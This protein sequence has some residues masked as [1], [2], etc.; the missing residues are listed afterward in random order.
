M[1]IRNKLVLIQLI[2]AFAVLVSASGILFVHQAN[3]SRAELVNSLSSTAML[4]GGNS[5]STLV[6]LDDV[7]AQRVL[8]SLQVK[9]AIVN[10]C[11]YDGSGTL[12]AAYSREG[13]DE[14][15]FPAGPDSVSHAFVD[16]HLLLFQPV[17][18]DADIIGWVF[19]RSDLSQLDELT[20]Q[21]VT[22][23]IESVLIGMILS[24]LLALLLQ[25]TISQPILDLVTTTRDVSQTGD[26]SR[27][28][29]AVADDEL[30][31]LSATFNEMLQQ[32]EGRDASLQ[33]ARDTLELRVDERTRELLQAKEQLEQALRSE[34][35]ARQAAEAANRTKTTFLANMSHEIRTPMNAILGYTQI[36]QGDSNLNTEHLRAIDAIAD[37]GEHLRRLINDVL[38]ISKIEAGREEFRPSEFDLRRVVESVSIMFESHCREKGLAWSLEENITADRVYGDESKLRQVLINLLGNAVKF[39]SQG[40]VTLKVVSTDDVHYRFTVSDTG[41]GIPREHWSEIFEP[42]Q[43]DEQGLIQGGTG[44]G[45]AIARRQVEI[46]GG[47]LHLEH[48]TSAGSRFSFTALL[49]GIG[50]AADNSNFIT[51]DPETDEISWSRVQELEDG[52]KVQALIVDD[53]PTNRDI[54]EQMLTRI[55][56]DV[57]AVESGERAIQ[58]VRT[59]MPDIVFMD[60]RM[61]GG[62]TGV[63]AMQQLVEEHGARATKIVAVTASVFEHQRQSFMTAGFEGFIGKPLR[64]E[65][66]YACLS[67]LLGVRYRLAPQSTGEETPKPSVAGGIRLP[68]V[69]HAGLSAAAAAH[70]I[71]DLNRELDSLEQTGVEG[72]ELAARL[73][74]RCRLFDIAS[75]QQILQGVDVQ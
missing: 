73:R 22:S 15:N 29:T 35:E 41:P 7:D 20:D 10:A 43:Q 58:S 72:S 61:P 54:L 63:E 69:L 52:F 21:Y 30:G 37:G 68:A 49:K 60:I 46:M 26:Y 57:E 55:G 51:A 45:L 25:R 65:Q 48:S 17:I 40:E 59:R 31:T 23:A 3:Q 14:F 33:E 9:P 4:I 28:A 50:Q 16:D 27:R 34:H 2:T 75:V 70:S 12:F 44:L 62:M 13:G 6:F 67:T 5:I 56:V 11:I 47:Q 39:T 74:E 1:S 8:T 42:F 19:L 64:V 53:V 38:D 71:T 24:A 66:L 32:I 18:R 36:L